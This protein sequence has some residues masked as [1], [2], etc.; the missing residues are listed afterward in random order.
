MAPW[1]AGK[2]AGQ[3]EAGPLAAVP[4]AHREAEL[5][6]A[7][8]Q[9]RGDGGARPVESGE[10]QAQGGDAAGQGGQGGLLQQRAGGHQVQVQLL[11]GWGEG[12]WTGD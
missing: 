5:R 2:K 10:D 7:P 9:L 3:M 1:S 6:E 4:P 12:G 11:V 8:R